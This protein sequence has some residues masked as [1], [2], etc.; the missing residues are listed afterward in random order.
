MNLRIWVLDRV[1]APSPNLRRKCQESPWSLS[2]PQSTGNDFGR[3]L[4]P[5]IR[6]ADLNEH[7]ARNRKNGRFLVS[8]DLSEYYR[9][10]YTHSVPWALHGK[11]FAKDNRT[12]KGLPGNQIDAALRRCQFDETMGLAVGPDASFLVGEVILSAVDRELAK[13]LSP[14][15]A[16]RYYDDYELV[17]AKQDEAERALGVIQNVLSE[18]NLLA[19]PTKT[20][21]NRLPQPIDNRWSASLSNFNLKHGPGLTHR[22]I[23]FFDAIDEH[24]RQA[25][26]GQVVGYAIARFEESQLL[27]SYNRREWDLVQSMLYHFVVNEPSALLPLIKLLAKIEVAP[28]EASANKVNKDEL[29]VALNQIIEV[30]A[31][32]GHASETA[33]AIWGLIAFHQSVSAGAAR[34][35]SGMQDSVVALLT[36]DAQSRGLIEGELNASIWSSFMNGTELYGNQWL[37]A[38]EG[39]MQGWLGTTAHILADPNFAVL[40]ANNVRF[41]TRFRRLTPKV[42]EDLETWTSGYDDE[43]DITRHLDHFMDEDDDDELDREQPY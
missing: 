41:Y 33:W 24:R 29:A 39:P 30:S 4:G 5:S 28:D 8:A 13:C 35:V 9:S 3:C 34:A 43:G 31:P 21:I 1:R 32:L 19:N 12:D 25:A 22:I 38:Y 2:K 18:Y 40:A 17:F 15:S 42:V 6:F 37:L 10:V 27:N 36:L 20:R 11:G 14:L 16:T 7:R 26:E 23:R